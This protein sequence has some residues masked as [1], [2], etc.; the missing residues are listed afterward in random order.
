MDLEKKYSFFQMQK[1][2]DFMGLQYKDLYSNKTES[3]ILRS[4][5]YKERTNVLSYYIIK[6]ILLQHYPLF[7]EWCKK[8][9]LS[10]LQF[11]KTHSCLDSFCD[12]IEEHYKSR[13]MLQGVKTMEEYLDVL[14]NSKR[15]K[16]MKKIFLLNNMRMSICELG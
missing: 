6:T 3:S 1:T 14:K 15:K 5:L 10:L 7:L 16:D 2:L 8:N 11:K 12:F 9:N 13:S 4:T